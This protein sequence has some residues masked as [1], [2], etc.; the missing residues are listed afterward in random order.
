MQVEFARR[1]GLGHRCSGSSS[2]FISRIACGTCV[3]WQCN[4]KFAGERKCQ[5]PHLRDEDIKTQ[6]LMA[7]NQLLNGKDALLA[8]C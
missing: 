3:V 2:M 1:K 5:T 8:N 6:F 7:F 4:E